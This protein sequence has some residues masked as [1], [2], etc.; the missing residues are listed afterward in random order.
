MQGLP[1][2]LLWRA[3]Y[4]MLMPT[5]GR[6]VRIW[7]E[8]S[9]SLFFAA[10]ITH[11][12][13]TR[14]GE[15]DARAPSVPIPVAPSSPIPNPNPSPRRSSCSSKNPP[16]SPAPPAA[17]AWALPAPWP[18][19]GADILLNGFGN[20]EEIEFTRA[21]LERQHGVKVRYSGADMSRPEQI[22]AMAELAHSEFGKVDIVV[23][24]A[25]IQHVAPIEDFPDE[26]SGTPCWRSTCRRRST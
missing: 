8:W 2:W 1:A 7:L 21:E 6:K 22:R 17:S 12:R 13:F 3:Y 16:S 25:G 15:V 4:L 20:A 19:S 10:D 11:L 5:L 9:W 26:T 24:N 14:T 23:N 18:R